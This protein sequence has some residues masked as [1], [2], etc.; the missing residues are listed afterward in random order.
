M[1]SIKEIMAADPQLRQRDNEH[2]KK[3]RAK[4]FSFVK[5]RSWVYANVYPDP[6]LLARCQEIIK[7]FDLI[8]NTTHWRHCREVVNQS[9]KI[10]AIMPSPH[11][12]HA[13]IRH[14]IY[15]MITVCKSIA[16]VPIH[17]YYNQKIQSYENV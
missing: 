6:M 3:L 4:L 17:I 9:H 7:A 10:R 16:T 15:N 11:A 14:R 12:K 5:Q 1:K 8:Q 13:L 2:T